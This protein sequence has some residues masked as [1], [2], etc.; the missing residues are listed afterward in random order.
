MGRLYSHL[1]TVLYVDFSQSIITACMV[2]SIGVAM[3]V[4]STAIPLFVVGR[5]FAGFGV[6]VVSTVVPMY[7]SEW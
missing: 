3:Q 2:F 6:G 4:A 7:Q 1:F 5:V